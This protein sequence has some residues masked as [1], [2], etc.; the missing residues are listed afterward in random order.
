MYCTCVAVAFTVYGPGGAPAHIVL[1][2]HTDGEGAVLPADEDVVVADTVH[3][4]TFTLLKVTPYPKAGDVTPPGNYQ[5]WL[6]VDP[7]AEAAPPTHTA[8]GTPFTLA[9]G[10]TIELD[11]PGERDDTGMMVAVL[12]VADSR[13]P[14]DLECGAGGKNGVE[15]GVL[16][17]DQYGQTEQI[18]LTGRTGYDGLLLPPTGEMQP[19]VTVGDYTLK[20]LRVTP[21]PQSSDA[22]ASD[23]YKVTLIVVGPGDAPAPPATPEPPAGG[24]IALG[25]PFDLRLHAEATVVDPATGD[26]L[27]V[28]FTGIQEDS[29]CPSDVMCAW[30]GVAGLEF[31][32][33]APGGASERFVLGGYTDP[34]GKVVPVMETGIPP[35]KWL[36]GYTIT[37][38]RIQPYPAHHDQAIAP[39][40]YVATLVVTKG[41]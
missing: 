27:Q 20:L 31:E 18:K 37:I 35:L 26:G 38:A 10:G 22:I 24:E 7:A 5:A 19:Q 33:T 12:S 23:G 29:L 40:D 15:V 41:E 30:S 25:V 9:P 4:F 21:F 17:L 14:I 2:A 39:E 16:V 34:Q 28:Q 8:P 3:G 6:R 32:A 13:C 11:D 1:T 36:D